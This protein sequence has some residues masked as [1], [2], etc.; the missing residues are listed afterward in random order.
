LL[1]PVG[2]QR[3]KKYVNHPYKIYEKA[4]EVLKKYDEEEIK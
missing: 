3:F 4:N 2:F 1:I